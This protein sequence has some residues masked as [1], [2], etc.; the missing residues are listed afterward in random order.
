MYHP[1]NSLTGN[2]FLWALWF[3]LA[4]TALFMIAMNFI[5]QPLTTAQAPYGIVSFELV[6][7]VTEARAILSSW[8]AS[9]QLRAAFIQ[10]LD[11]L[12]LLI[13]STAFALACL[14]AGRIL[15]QNRWPLSGLGAW[16]AWGQGLAAFCDLIENIALVVMLFGIVEMPWQVIARL[17][18][19]CKFGLLFTGMVY[20][21]YGGVIYLAHHLQSSAQDVQP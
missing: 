9:A 19:M 6:K 15:K 2:T 21:F 7:D 13:Y 4:L 14:G 3:L 12:F 8:N 11:C 20:M 10:G 1:L 5:G 16:V 17:N 18:A